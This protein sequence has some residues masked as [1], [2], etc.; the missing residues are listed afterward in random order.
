MASVETI[1]TGRTINWT[2]FNEKLSRR[3][4][5]EYQK[6]FG[7]KNE[8]DLSP[9]VVA[10]RDALDLFPVPIRVLYIYQG[11]DSA[12]SIHTLIHLDLSRPK[13]LEAEF[14]GVVP[15][16]EAHDCRL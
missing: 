9:E 1:E 2:G 5:G 6:Q 13:S 3:L 14:L 11:K 12:E 7:S 4:R 8:N 16:A 10:F 15:V